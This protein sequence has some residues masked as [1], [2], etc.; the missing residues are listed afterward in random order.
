MDL[1]LDRVDDL[2]L[3][4]AFQW[5]EVA[6]EPLADDRVAGLL[7]NL[8][9]EARPLEH[10][11]NVQDGVLG[12]AATARVCGTQRFVG[13]EQCQGREAEGVFHAR[14][15]VAVELAPKDAQ[16]LAVAWSRSQP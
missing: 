9:S 14:S 10:S 15:P 4:A 3:V 5:V 12:A 6:V 16:A 8:A 2:Q 7:Q 1:G 11:G 13:F